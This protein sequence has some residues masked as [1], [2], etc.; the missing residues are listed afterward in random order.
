MALGPLVLAYDAECSLCVKRAEALQARD[1]RGLLVLFPLQHPELVRMAP[2]LAGLKLHG[3]LHGLDLATRRVF[4]G[5]DLL[6]ELAAR[7]PRWAWAAPLL[8]L[9]GLAKAL[10]WFTLRRDEARFRRSGRG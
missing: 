1:T 4:K 9:P 5:P 10:A 6:P 7:L 3:E 2:E 8:R